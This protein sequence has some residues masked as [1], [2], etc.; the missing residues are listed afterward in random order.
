MTLFCE[1][2]SKLLVGQTLGRKPPFR[3]QKD[4]FKHT[5]HRYC[6]E[7]CPGSEVRRG[8]QSSCQVFTS[9]STYLPRAPAGGIPVGGFPYLLSSWEQ[10]SRYRAGLSEGWAGAVLRR[11]D[12]L[13]SLFS[14]I[15]LPNLPS[16][17]RFQIIQVRRSNTSFLLV[18]SEARPVLV[19]SKGRFFLLLVSSVNCPHP[20]HGVTFP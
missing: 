1:F 18:S 19:L 2:S 7:V 3:D 4:I 5:C 16:L 9:E 17:Q 20:R 13:V 10:V 15:S 14:L 8:C 6:R 11:S 12:L